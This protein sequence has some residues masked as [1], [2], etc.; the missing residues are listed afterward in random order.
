M[1]G[2]VRC[3][4]QVR[5]VARATL[6][7]L[8]GQKLTDYSFPYAQAYPNTGHYTA[9][10]PGFA[11]ANERETAPE[12]MENTRRHDETKHLR[13]CGKKVFAFPARRAVEGKPHRSGTP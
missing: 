1:V 7:Q 4:T 12:A 6:V 3:Q 5:D 11:E 8:T 9:R 10:C 13:K 2:K